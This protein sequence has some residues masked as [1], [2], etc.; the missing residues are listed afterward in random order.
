MTLENIKKGVIANLAVRNKYTLEV[1]KTI[2]GNSYFGV[3]IFVGISRMFDYSLNEIQEHLSEDLE[4]VKFMEEK[5][6]I[7]L[8][9]YFNGEK[10]DTSK[11]FHTKTSLI[12]NFIKNNYGKKVSLAEIIKDQIK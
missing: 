6:R 5:F 10:G 12:L 3:C 11:N 2:E 4:T 7:I 9:D 8:N 1:D